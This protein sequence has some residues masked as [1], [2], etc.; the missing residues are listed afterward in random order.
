[1][2]QAIYWILAITVMVLLLINVIK[3]M[4]TDK[5][6]RRYI[7]KQE[8]MLDRQAREMFLKDLKEIG[9]MLENMNNK[10]KESK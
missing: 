3:T 8:A 10:E 2:L 4:K 9:E 6:F 1:M 5:Q 7:K